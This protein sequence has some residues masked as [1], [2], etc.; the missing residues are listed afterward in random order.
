MNSF[1]VAVE[2]AEVPPW[3]SVRLHIVVVALKPAIGLPLLPPI[4][5]VFLKGKADDNWTFVQDVAQLAAHNGDVGEGVL[6]LVTSV[7]HKVIREKSL[8]WNSIMGVVDKLL[9]PL[10]CCTCG[11]EDP[12]LH[13]HLEQFWEVNTDIVRD[14]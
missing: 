5:I 9:E 8:Q 14:D 4:L 13:T 7:S 6:N 11:S 1:S 3:L 12:V 2:E 10:G